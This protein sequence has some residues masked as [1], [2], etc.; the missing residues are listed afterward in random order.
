MSPE[1]REEM[2][3][4]MVGVLEEARRKDPRCV[5]YLLGKAEMGNASLRG[6]G[7]FTMEERDGAIVLSVLSLL[8]G[9]VGLDEDGQSPFEVERDDSGNVLELKQRRR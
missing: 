7:L 8:E 2:V 3:R 5:K 6:S 9:L 1:N 4:H